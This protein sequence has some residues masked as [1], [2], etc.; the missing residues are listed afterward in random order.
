L[1]AA[2]AAVASGCAGIMGKRAAEDAVKA[3]EAQSNAGPEQQIARVAATRAV[4]GA[5]S[6]LEEPRRRKS[7]SGW[8]TRRSP[9]PHPAVEKPP[10]RCSRSSGRRQRAARGQPSRTGERVSASAMGGVGGRSRVAPNAWPGPAWLSRAAAAD[11][12]LDGGVV[13]GRHQGRRWLALLLVAFALAP[14]VA[15]WA[16][17]SVAAYFRRRGLRMVESQ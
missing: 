16:R 11:G 3:I 4:E 17:G 13:H 15:C 12:A 9:P 6:A 5:V 10:S 1:I 8:S 14:A 7:S 2:L